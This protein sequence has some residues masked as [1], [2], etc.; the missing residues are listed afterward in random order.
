MGVYD[1]KRPIPYYM[2]T[3]HV[4]CRSR[5]AGVSI[6]NAQTDLTNLE[7]RANTLEA[8]LADVR[9]EIERIKIYLE[10][11]ERYGEDG[12]G[13]GA[14]PKTPQVQP[15]RLNGG[16]HHPAHG[17]AAPLEDEPLIQACRG[18]SIPDAAIELIRLAGRPLSENE[19]VDRLKRG[20]VTFVSNTP[21]VTLRFSLLRK[22]KESGALKV[23]NDKLWDLGDSAEH[24]NEATK[25]SGFVQNRDRNNH[26]ERSR[27]GL[28]EARKRG[29]KN[30]RKFSITPEMKE[31]AESLLAEGA[32]FGEIAKLIG[33][34]SVTFARWRQLGLVVIPKKSTNP[35]TT[36]SG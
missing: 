25:H 23:N 20:G 24:E 27:Q 22:R 31:V 30:G 21:A 18:K 1:D 32:R 28:L 26:A 9:A 10:L 2:N 29:V 7:A 13:G 34:S 17:N 6:E 4:G 14:A 15:V 8:E 35:D 33:V 36:S 3:N 5:G 12:H 19:I 11:S 16:A